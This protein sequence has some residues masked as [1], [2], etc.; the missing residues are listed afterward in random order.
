[1]RLDE[2]GVG[3][4]KKAMKIRENQ[5]KP[6]MVL[7]PNLKKRGSFLRGQVKE[8]EINKGKLKKLCKET[9]EMKG[10]YKGKIL[11]LI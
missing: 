10:I 7:E 8:R 2:M 5:A 1:M 11:K 9:E 3:N 6:F 4:N